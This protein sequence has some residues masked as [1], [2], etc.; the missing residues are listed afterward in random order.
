MEVLKVITE[1]D[2]EEMECLAEDVM[3]ALYMHYAD[4][5]EAGNDL[6]EKYYARASS[7]VE[8]EQ[9]Y[10]PEYKKAIEIFRKG[11]GDRGET[12][13]VVSDLASDEYLIAPMRK[14]MHEKAVE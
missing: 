9:I 12:N 8:W 11:T 6:F 4:Y 1:K 2:I 3:H 7:A 10:G 5:D 14:R 13:Y